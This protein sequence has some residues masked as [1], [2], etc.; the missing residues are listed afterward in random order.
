M[1]SV[2]VLWVRVFLF[3]VLAFGVAAPGDVWGQDNRLRHFEPGSVL[4]F[5]KFLTGT[6]VDND[7]SR[8]PRSSFEI[9]VTCPPGISDV[10]RD[11]FCFD[12]LTNLPRTV[13]LKAKWVCPSTTNR[14]FEN[15]CPAYD[16]LLSTTVNGTLWINP[17]NIPNVPGSP[18]GGM[19]DPPPP[20]CPAG[21]LIVWAVN[22][23]TQQLPISFNGLLGDA[24]LRPSDITY[25]TAYNAVSI[26]ASDVTGIPTSTDRNRLDFD[27]DRYRMLTER[28][29]GTVRYGDA[30]TRTFLTLL[31]LNIDANV[32][33]N[34]EYPIEFNFYNE[35]EEL[36]SAGIQLVCWRDVDL[37]TISP[38]LTAV[39]IRGLKGLVSADNTDRQS[40]LG[41]I[42]TEEVIPN[43]G[44][45]LRGYAY[46]V[47]NDRSTEVE[48]SFR[49]YNNP[50]NP[51][52]VPTPR[53]PVPTPRLPLPALP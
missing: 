2:A 34:Q 12:P 41:I 4:V 40:L 37:A 13:W 29:F 45:L 15:N 53:L 28:F 25:V 5:P 30:N 51:L 32:N 39:G 22:N 35:R 19:P 27:G 17:E 16:F 42:R 48:S 8:F 50:G 44:G 47:Y 1:K 20:G 11:L 46:S 23:Q 6:V 7:G 24:I 31:T 18:N 14:A 10:D 33:N 38:G 52:P 3:A 43:S 49:Q 36:A 9:S 21:F 26:Q